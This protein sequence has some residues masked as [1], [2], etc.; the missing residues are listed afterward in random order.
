MCVGT[1]G[2][3]CEVNINDCS[4][5]P[6]RGGARCVDWTDDFYC[7]CPNGTAGKTCGEY[8]SVTEACDEY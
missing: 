2:E 6:C 8:W 7:M 5:N 1:Q 4:P 3:V